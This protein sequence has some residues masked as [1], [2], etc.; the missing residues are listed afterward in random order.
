MDGLAWSFVRNVLRLFAFSD[1]VWTS[2]RLAL[3]LVTRNGMGF[4]R[5]IHMMQNFPLLLSFVTIIYEITRKPERGER[6]CRSH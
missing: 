1:V 2:A 3:V 6:I 5:A 4:Q